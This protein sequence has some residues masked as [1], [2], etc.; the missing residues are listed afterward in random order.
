MN[1]MVKQNLIFTEVDVVAF[2]VCFLINH[3]DN[4]KN[5]KSKEK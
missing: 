1:L 3:T 4:K 2:L 5:V